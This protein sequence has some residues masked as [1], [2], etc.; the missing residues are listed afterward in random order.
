[1]LH[2]TLGG[3]ATGDAGNVELLSGKW[4]RTRKWSGLSGE[5]RANPKRGAEPRAAISRHVS[6][7]LPSGRETVLFRPSRKHYLLKVFLSLRRTKIMAIDDKLE[8]KLD[9][10]ASSAELDV[11]TEVIKIAIKLTV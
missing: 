7:N 6:S 9:Q 5:C 3:M 1:M 2:P 10:L 4:A 8:K 11:G